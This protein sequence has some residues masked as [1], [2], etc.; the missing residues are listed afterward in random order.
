M[1]PSRFVVLSYFTRGRLA[2]SLLYSLFIAPR[3]TF[4]V[5]DTPFLRGRFYMLPL[6]GW[7]LLYFPVFSL[8]F[9]HMG[10]L[11]WVI[12]L[13]FLTLILV[14]PGLTI[15][16]VLSFTGLAA[17][18]FRPSRRPF[19]LGPCTTRNCRTTTRPAGPHIPR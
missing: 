11:H 18:T 1:G 14:Y 10:L 6:G 13:S 16:F 12:L 17:K 19:P 5:P 4:Y 8:Y 7:L 9:A 15:G 3:F 2:G